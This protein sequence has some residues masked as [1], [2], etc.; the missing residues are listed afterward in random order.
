M[1]ELFCSH[2]PGR[3]LRA[4]S[5][6]EDMILLHR[7]DSPNLGTKQACLFRDDY[8]QLSSTGLSIYGLSADSPKANT[9]FKSKQSLPYSLLCDVNATLITA[10]GFG[11]TPKGTVRGVF[12]VDKKDRVLACQAGGPDATVKVVQELVKADASDAQKI[13]TSA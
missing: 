5:R 12:A 4:V 10:V 3:P 13:D 7:R 6:P 9:T 2:I 8:D 11:K 1:L